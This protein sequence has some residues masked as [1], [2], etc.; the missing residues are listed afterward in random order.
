MRR[1]NPMSYRMLTRLL[2]FARNDN[3]GVFQSSPFGKGA[4]GFSY[5]LKQGTLMKVSLHPHAQDRLHERGAT[6]EEVI[7]TIERGER[8]PAKHGRT[9]FRCTF[10]SMA[11]G[12]TGNIRQN[13]LRRMPS[14]KMAGW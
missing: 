4:G 3:R 9:E 8:F 13:R 7:A 5:K 14:R 1:G 6:E 12:I 2:R 10:H 11:S